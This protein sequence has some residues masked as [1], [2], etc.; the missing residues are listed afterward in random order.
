MIARY[1][2]ECAQ[3]G[4]LIAKGEVCDYDPEVKLI[5]HKVCPQMDGESQIE[6]A[7][8]LGYMPHAIRDEDIPF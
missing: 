4:G 6:L 5:A 1:T 8:R 3:C 2:G 7:E